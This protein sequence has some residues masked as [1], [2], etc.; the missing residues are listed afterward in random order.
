MPVS[1][2]LKRVELIQAGYDPDELDELHPLPE[3]P[4]PVV[5]QEPPK[6]P[7]QTGAIRSVFTHALASA[8]SAAIGLQAGAGVGGL[9][10]A[11]GGPLVG[12]PAGITAT[13]LGGLAARK[14]QDALIREG[15]PNSINDAYQNELATTE[16]EHP[17][18][19]KIGDALG[20][21]IALKP[22]WDTIKSAG[23]AILN[24]LK[25][26][27]ASAADIGN[28]ANVSLGA[29]S[30]L[31]GEVQKNF[32]TKDVLGS[33]QNLP[34]NI[35]KDF[36]EDPMGMLGEVAVGALLNNPNK[37]GVKLGMHPSVIENDGTKGLVNRVRGSEV[38]QPQ[39]KGPIA[40]LPERSGAPSDK[41]SLPTYT[42]DAAGNVVNDLTGVGINPTGIGEALRV[43]PTAKPGINLPTT[44]G[45]IIAS[46]YNKPT[47]KL[48]PP[49]PTKTLT[50]INEQL[51]TAQPTPEV[52]AYQQAQAEH[53]LAQEKI[54]AETARLQLEAQKL[55]QQLV[56]PKAAEYDIPTI[57]APKVDALNPS[58]KIAEP[59]PVEPNPKDINYQTD[60][61]RVQPIVEGL[62]KNNL[63]VQPTTAWNDFWQGFAKK[64]NVKIDD[65]GRV[66]D[67]TTGKEVLGQAFYRDGL[68][69]ALVKINPNKAD[70]T[71][72]PHE[73]FH[74][75][76]ED[77]KRMGTPKDKALLKRAQRVIQE[78]PEYVDWA[79]RKSNAG[80]S[81]T[82]DEYLTQLT[83]E[84]SVR[85]LLNTD[86]TGNIRNWFRDFWAYQKSRF[87]K[88]SNEDI[89]RV[90]SNRLI[91]DPS[92]Q[93][94]FSGKDINI[95]TRAE[96]NKPKGE[97]DIPK[98][99]EDQFKGEVDKVN[100]TIPDKGSRLQESSAFP[101]FYNKAPYILEDQSKTGINTEAKITPEHLLN[102]LKNKL[103][104]REF[105]AL[106]EAGLSKFLS[107]KKS[108]REV[109]QYARENGPKIETKELHAGIIGSP[110]DMRVTQEFDNNLH[111]LET[112][113]IKYRGVSDSGVGGDE[114]IAGEWHPRFSVGADEGEF[115]LLPNN[116]VVFKN[117]Q[118]R[119]TI[120][121]LNI[122]PDQKKML[123]KFNELHEPYSR[124]QDNLSS[125]A[126]NNESATARYSMVNPKPLDKM[127]GA[128]DLLVRVP[129]DYDK[130]VGSLKYASNH[131]P[132]E[133]KNL[134][135]HV[136]GNMETL[137]N[138]KKVF[139]IFEV[140]SDWAQARHEAEGN[141]KIVEEDGK[142]LLRTKRS[143][144]GFL[145]EFD[146]KEEAL[147]ELNNRADE[148]TKKDPLLKDYERLALKTAIEHARKNGA[149]YIAISDAETAMLTEGHDR[150]AEFGVHPTEQNKA[151]ASKLLEDDVSFP[152]H[153]TL[154]HIA[155]GK[156]FILNEKQE[157]HFK[158]LGF[159]VDRTPTQE[160]GMRLHYDKTLPKIAEELTG[161]KGERVSFGEHKN[162]YEDGFRGGNNPTPHPMEVPRKDLIFKNTDGT[163]KTDITAKLYPIDKAKQSFSLFGS[164]KPG[165]T[166]YQESS[167][168]NKQT[169]TPEF[170]SWFGDSKV[171]D[172]EGKPQHNYHVSKEAHTEFKDKYKSDLSALGFHFGTKEQAETR[173]T[174]YDF[175]SK[176]PNTSKVFLKIEN[177][178][179]VSHMASFAPDHLADK[180]MD[181]GI[182]TE[183]A[184]SK[185]R[186]KYSEEPKVGKE[187]VK[188][189]KKN[190]YD[191][192]KYK[193]EREGSG[194][195]YVTFEPT[196]IKSATGNSGEFSKTNPDIR[197][198][199]SSPFQAYKPEVK[200]TGSKS[201]TKSKEEPTSTDAPYIPKILQSEN[202]KIRKIGTPEAVALSRGV[203][204]YY[205]DYKTIKGKLNGVLQ[206][207]ISKLGSVNISDVLKDPLNPQKY[208]DYGR[209]TS[210]VLDVT[211]QKMLDARE[212]KTPTFTSEEQDI[213]KEIQKTLKTVR[214]ELR[215]RPG[216]RD[217][218]KSVDD[219]NYIPH[220][221][222]TDVIDNLISDTQSPESLA[223]QKQFLDYQ[224]ARGA[225]E[226]KAKQNL[227]T[228][229]EAYKTKT[230]DIA[231]Q[232]GALD[233]AEG[234]G[235]PKEWRETNLLN[236]MH[237]YL[238]R[239]SRRFA[240]FDNI[241]SNPKAMGALSRHSG[242]DSIKTVMRD[243]Q[244]DI[245]HTD[246]TFNAAQGIVR[247][248][249]LG[250]LTGARDVTSNLTLGWQH[251]QNPLQAIKTGIGAIK[252]LGQYI[253]DGV[254][255]GRIRHN[256]NSLEWSD[257]I[258]GLRRISDVISD[259]QGRNFLEKISRGYSTGVGELTTLDY[260]ERYN[261]GKLGK[262]GEAWFEKFGDGIDWK[263]GK[264]SREDLLKMAGRFTDSSQGAY[265]YTGLPKY[266]R[267]GVA[268][269]FLSLSRWNVEKAN[270][271]FKNVIDPLRKG[272]PTPFLMSTLGMVLGGSAVVALTE[273]ITGRK[274]KTASYKELEAAQ[275]DGKNI[276]T[277]AMYKALGLASSA[278]YAGIV[279][280]VAKAMMDRLYAKT[281]P[282]WFNNLTLDFADSAMTTVN[283]VVSAI[284][285]DGFDPNILMDAT[286]HIIAD[287]LQMLRLAYNHL[288]PDAKEEVEKS[289]KFRDLR[290]FKLLEGDKVS[291][292]SDNDYSRKYT[293][294]DIKNYKQEQ[295]LDKAQ[296][297][298]PKLIEK[299][300]LK[301][302]GDPQKLK[303]EFSKIKRNSYQT[304]P[305]P[306]T[307]SPMFF[308]YL[309]NLEKTQGTE[310][311][312]KRLQDYLERNM[313]NKIKSSAIPTLAQ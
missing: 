127:P 307:D 240:Y 246:K 249:A 163:P 113:G 202:D 4:T 19:S 177:P 59:L 12:I 188:I 275:E 65:S 57:E 58:V 39:T 45:Q 136:R 151:L 261:Q 153:K 205:D 167:A 73:F 303:D 259:V 147:A 272:N 40:L 70:I 209:N 214:D 1:N 114:V 185:I 170:K 48:L 133:G 90:M 75:F 94:R 296:E 232:F 120:D 190:G 298:I 18:A 72:L 220:V 71:T 276:I 176:N 128:V 287:H 256:I 199:E 28:L 273:A 124:A 300:F 62:Q 194:Y 110:E 223:L 6:K 212:G 7:L 291:D 38:V 119:T 281:K 102:T 98:V 255:N 289:N 302:D 294:K 89:A 226:V 10:T 165:S 313:K 309:T 290:T 95:N 233:K 82:V 285:E 64:R 257:T 254:E 77:L 175:S 174:Q 172:D 166:M 83:G 267:E 37:L 109:A 56:T 274:D 141:L 262:Q 201:T 168:F 46:E 218:S 169:E 22:S 31:I 140:Q 156:S 230:T 105:E 297:M 138:G 263:K 44:E 23:K 195:S 193:N 103:S 252:D 25:G 186:D 148:H 78:S 224:Q 88:G 219:P 108:P 225:S 292:N 158:E 157:S 248:A 101:Q 144:A 51:Q 81:S 69:E 33:L 278:G 86:S 97:V 308:R 198:Q 264:I 112:S 217:I 14:A 142:W 29:S 149:D 84:D 231:G 280:D 63:P 242:N 197:Y 293:D 215:K 200:N 54:K 26:N 310:A 160:K 180:M 115:F 282:R 288:D 132:T 8:P 111:E 173:S 299:A 305:N 30:P 178:L 266:T 213:R 79:E 312:Q 34:S 42:V 271:Y 253:S 283:N 270:N 15:L 245:T 258:G 107:E 134:L 204:R 284:N 123:K 208:K 269:P 234:F 20:G 184:Y 106:Q 250:T 235:L 304:M 145:Q 126:G 41:S 227:K 121:N 11:I 279:A 146:T 295:D 135:A 171:V 192:L 99:M 183:D 125:L 74:T 162:A 104:P 164:D 207:T 152:S 265:D 50:D 182:L 53:A 24:P 179:E 5:Q 129:Y 60:A 27:P 100:R 80:E 9:G 181:L 161:A 203:S 210:P 221:L 268:S 91:N 159:S 286:G 118:R 189:L 211:Y 206:N 67:N 236:A 122:Q 32:D 130:K 137:P 36:K 76:Y 311:A 155:S 139:H 247:S 17:T 47:P 93:E 150:A 117:T 49:A 238:D 237:R 35:Y 222:K 306:E 216:I 196:Q 187:L 85:R 244:G 229:L 131:Y 243:I 154:E 21:L 228:I 66:F 2:P 87:G 96:D 92:F 241:E 16:Q 116:D 191:G 3:T 61:E 52:Q 251:Q 301:A 13:I 143:D 260:L 239:V 55:N 43:A 277:P 68:K